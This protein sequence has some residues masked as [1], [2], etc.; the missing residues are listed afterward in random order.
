[1]TEHEIMDPEDLFVSRDEDD[2]L[3]PVEQKMPGVEQKLRV[4]PMTKGQVNKYEIQSGDFSDITDE[5]LADIFNSHLADLDRELDES[6]VT[7]DMIGFGKEALLKTILRASGFDMQN[8][9]N[10]ENLQMIGD[11]DEGNLETLMRLQEKQ[12]K[13]SG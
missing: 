9:I 1:M 7:E 13:R 11:M 4:I 8:A 12:T 10:K 2:N 5:M 3:Q 6:H